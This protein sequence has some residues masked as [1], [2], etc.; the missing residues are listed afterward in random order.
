MKKNE[1]TDMIDL[2]LKFDLKFYNENRKMEDL[3]NE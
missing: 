1:K 2:V 3:K